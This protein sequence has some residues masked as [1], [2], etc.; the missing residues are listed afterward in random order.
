MDYRSSPFKHHRTPLTLKD[1][2]QGDPLLSKGCFLGFSDKSVFTRVHN[3]D[4]VDHF[5]V[6]FKEI[7]KDIVTMSQLT[8]SS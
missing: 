4:E 3:T 7:L 1:T 2:L 5:I 8:Y 6:V